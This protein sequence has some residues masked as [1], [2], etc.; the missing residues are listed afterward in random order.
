MALVELDAVRAAAKNIASVAVRTPLL[1]CTWADN[2]WLKPESLQPVGSF[3]LRGAV[4]ALSCLPASVRRAGVIAHSSGNHAQAVAY[5]GRTL[6]TP[7]VVVMPDV[8]AP[9]KVAATR[10]YGAEVFLVPAAERESRTEQLAAE[11]GL[12]IVPPYDHADII[13]GQGTVGLEIIEDL[14]D[15]DTVL[16]P[17]GGGGLSSGVATAVT[18]LAPHATVIGVEPELAS[19]AAD[20]LRAGELRM[21]DTHVTHRTAADGLRTNLSPLTFAHLRARL[22]GIVTVTEE[23]ILSTVGV[24]ARSARLVAE[25][26][27]AVAVAAYLHRRDELPGGRTV[28]IVS[29]GN[30]DPAVLAQALG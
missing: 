1:P 8:A 5:A 3:K 30:V 4:N 26:S 29:G 12:T 21:W 11:R 2:L 16:V 9:L 13:A 18:A 6:E 28:A 20:S 10:G 24:L 15:V 25:P 23:E 22:S 7:V 14:S 27:G 17:V 19:D